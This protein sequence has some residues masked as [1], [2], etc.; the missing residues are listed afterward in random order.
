MAQLLAVAIG[1]GVTDDPSREEA[2]RP[3]SPERMASEALP[4]A[5]LPSPTLPT[6]GGAIRGIGEKFS[7]TL[8]S[9][10]ASMSVPLYLTPG[11]AGFTP[12]LALV[13]D[14]GA[15]NGPFGVG[16]SL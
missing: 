2:T 14:S 4:F 11:R 6:G 7:A 10:T 15:G 5:S 16:W 1:A 12:Q 3:G 13:Y 8:P 9:G